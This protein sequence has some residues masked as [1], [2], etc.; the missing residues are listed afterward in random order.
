MSN[1]ILH[2]KISQSNTFTF[3]LILSSKLRYQLLLKA[4]LNLEKDLQDFINSNKYLPNAHHYWATTYRHL[5]SDDLEGLA[6][7]YYIVEIIKHT[8]KIQSNATIK[9]EGDFDSYFK[10]YIGLNFPEIQ[11]N[12]KSNFKDK[13]KYKFGPFKY[14]SKALKYALKK[15]KDKSKLVNKVWLST[16]T[17][18]KSLFPG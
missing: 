10:N 15:T 1:I 18:R 17:S 14:L 5:R 16:N 7:Y 13:L 12:V 3:N 9:I 2:I 11:L 8:V 4:N 6:M